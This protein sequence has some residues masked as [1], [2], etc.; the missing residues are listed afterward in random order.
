MR[1]IPLA[2]L[3]LAL[4]AGTAAPAAYTIAR[5]A[6]SNG[7]GGGVVS[8]VAGDRFPG[9]RSDGGPAK[10]ARL[11]TPYGIAVDTAG[12]LY[13]ADLG[14]NRVRKVSTAGT[15]TTVSGTETLQTPGRGR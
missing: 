6:G 15:I 11:N 7:V 9:F 14:N 10:A 3:P 13:I 8:T 12:N 5:V 1:F 2:L 4:L